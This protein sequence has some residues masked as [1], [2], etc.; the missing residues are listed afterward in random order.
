MG[1]PNHVNHDYLAQARSAPGEVKHLSNQRKRNRIDTVSSGERKRQSL[2]LFP[3]NLLVGG[4]GNRDDT[5]E[6]LTSVFLKSVLKIYKK[7]KIGE[8]VEWPWNGQPKKVIAL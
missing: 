4:R 2:N 3:V 5:L 6:F 7:L 8:L 1:K